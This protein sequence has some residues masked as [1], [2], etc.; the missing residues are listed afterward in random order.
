MLK[1]DSGFRTLY[2]TRNCSVERGIC[3]RA[4]STMNELFL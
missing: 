3:P 2:G 1:K 4:T